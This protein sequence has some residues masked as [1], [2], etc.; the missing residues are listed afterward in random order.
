MLDIRWIR[1]N[2]QALD[3]M[4]CKRGQAPIAK[5]LVEL[6]ALYRNELS[7]LQRLQAQKNQLSSILAHNRSEDLLKQAT[8]LK[9]L[10]ESLK[11]NTDHNKQKIHAILAGLPNLL[12]DSVPIGTSDA[13]NK[14]ISRWGTPAVYPW[15]K[16]HVTLGLD[17]GGLDLTQAAKVS[18]ARFVYL[19]KDL[20]KLERALGQWMLDIHTQEFGFTE[21]ATPYLVKENAVFNAGQLP[22]FREDLFCTTNDFFLISTSEVSLVNWAADK[23]FNDDKLPLCLTALTPCFRSEAGSAG[24]DTYGMIRLH[25]FN[26]VE[27]VVVCL[28][29]DSWDWHERLAQQ[30][31]KILQYLEL[32]YRKMLLCTSDTGSAAQKTYDLEV[33]IPSQ[34]CYREISSCSNCGDYQARRLNA[35]SAQGTYLHTLNGSG[36]PTGR[37]LVALLENYQQEDGSIKIPSILHPYMKQERLIPLT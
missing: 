2:P 17:L 26:K 12:D 37:T 21:M 25:Q 24:K 19:K 14:E 13:D 33:W 18:G 35:K 36:L 31:E 28:A 15:T 11:N 30:A 32:P 8:Q 27:L 16:D 3:A 5:E 6:D 34:Q 23:I 29:Q 10:I 1:Q 22:K 9:D 20:A 4:L 7:E